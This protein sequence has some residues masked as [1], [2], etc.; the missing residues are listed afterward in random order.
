MRKIIALILA[1]IC[2]MS[3]FTGCDDKNPN[4]TTEN[5]TDLLAPSPEEDFEF[6]AGENGLTVTK[7]LGS[8]KKVVIPSVVN[9]KK[10]V[11][12]N[13]DVFG[14]NIVVEEIVLSE[15]MRT[16]FLTAFRGCDNLKSITYPGVTSLAD[17]H[18]LNSTSLASYLPKNLT[19]MI[20]P[21]LKT[22]DVYYFTKVISYAP[23]VTTFVCENATELKEQ[24]YEIKDG[25]K[26]VVPEKLV[27]DIKFKT[28]NA[29]IEGAY[30]Y[31]YYKGSYVVDESY[32]KWIF[33]ESLFQAWKDEYS[34]R[35]K[36]AH[37]ESVFIGEIIDK[38]EV[39]I[40]IIKFV[41]EQI[42]VW[43]NNYGATDVESFYS[44]KY[45]NIS[46]H[47][48]FKDSDG[49]E[50]G[51]QFNKWFFYYDYETDTDVF[52]IDDFFIRYK[53]YKSVTDPNC[54]VATFFGTNSITINGVTYAYDFS[55]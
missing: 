19:T 54:A 9:N 12:I 30:K 36:V 35:D 32:A 49:I 55:E 39:D 40:G 29:F 1:L 18:N 11:N 51:Y 23:Q 24:S 26:L 34:N 2:L 10:V 48:R 28:V 4:V 3:V 44:E 17:D 37:G 33:E 27:D 52:F 25:I 16:L 46:A 15:H 53:F 42:T 8:D 14:G 41:E 31:D 50:Q 20:F 6:E 45:G 13:A 43:K 47:I 21:A 5:K 22:V 38:S 7:Y